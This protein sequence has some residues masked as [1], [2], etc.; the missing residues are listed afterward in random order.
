MYSPRNAKK[1]LHWQLHDAIFVLSRDHHRQSISRPFFQYGMVLPTDIFRI[2]YKDEYTFHVGAVV[3]LFLYY[4]DMKIRMY[5]WILS[6]LE[7]EV[8]IITVKITPHYDFL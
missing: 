6:N 4:Y 2:Q 3:P 5:L 7:I 1:M 8:L